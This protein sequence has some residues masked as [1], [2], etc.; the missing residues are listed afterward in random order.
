MIPFFLLML[1]TLFYQAVLNGMSVLTHA[2]SSFF[3]AA[4]V[5]LVLVIFC[6]NI[7][8]GLFLLPFLGMLLDAMTGGV[9][10]QHLVWMVI[11]GFS[12]MMLSSLLGKPHSPLILSFLLGS[13]LIYRL[14]LSQMGNWGISNL[15]LG[16]F[17][18][19][20]VGMLIF[21]C[22]P[23]RLIRMD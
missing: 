23:T 13:S 7:L 19:A 18:D 3:L 15:L 4:P 2:Y 16:P 12:G 1:F 5:V 11:F 17:A 14:W 9:A 8:S 6:M 10:G 21:Y 20:L 22:L